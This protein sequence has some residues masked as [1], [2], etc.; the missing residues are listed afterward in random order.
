MRE[1]KFRAWDKAT[2]QWRYGSTNPY[3]GDRPFTVMSLEAF[4]RWVGLPDIMAY[5][6]IGEYIGSHD[7]KGKEI[8]EGDIQL[9]DYG[10]GKKIAVVEYSEKDAA[11]IYHTIGGGFLHACREVDTKHNEIIGNTF[12]NPELTKR[13]A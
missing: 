1:I 13:E 6:S 12:E 9:L 8:Y 10:R 3:Y 7:K 11:F 2:K 4:W 5:E